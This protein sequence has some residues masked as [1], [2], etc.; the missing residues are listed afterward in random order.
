MP[1]PRLSFPTV[2]TPQNVQQQQI[3]SVSL[4]MKI[5]DPKNPN[6]GPEKI[7]TKEPSDVDETGV[8]AVLNTEDIM[9]QY[10][11]DFHTETIANANESPNI[12]HN[13][14]ME[15]S[16]AKPSEAFEK[17][18]TP[19]KSK[20]LFT[21]DCDAKKLDEITKPQFGG[22]LSAGGQ[23]ISISDDSLAQV[24]NLFNEDL[25]D[26][27]EIPKTIFGGFSSSGGQKNSISKE[28]LTQANN[29]F[30]EEHENV[31]EIPK[32]KFGGFSSA[33]GKKI[34]ISKESLDQV[35]NIFNEE[36][37]KVNEI[38]KALFGGFSSAGGKNIFISKESLAQVKNIFNDEP[39]KVNEVPTAQFGSFL[40]A[41]GGQKISICQESLV[42]VKNLFNEDPENVHV[43]PK[44][45]FCGFS[46]A[47]GKKISV[48]DKALAHVKNMFNGDIKEN[49]VD[50][51]ANDEQ[52]VEDFEV[53]EFEP[54][55]ELGL[56]SSPASSKTKRP[57]KPPAFAGFLSAKG[58]L[59]AI[60][61]DAAEKARKI[62]KE[63]DSPP[64]P[65]CSSESEIE[66]NGS[67]SKLNSITNETK[68]DIF[69]K[70]TT[71]TDLITDQQVSKNKRKLEDIETMSEMPEEKKLCYE[72]PFEDDFSVD[73]QALAE[74][75]KM[76]NG[77]SAIIS[78]TPKSKNRHTSCRLV[79][80]PEVSRKVTLSRNQERLKQMEIIKQKKNQEVVPSVEGSLHRKK[81]TKQFKLRDLQINR[82]N[83]VAM[84]SNVR[85]TTLDMTSET[86]ADH[87]FVGRQYFSDEIL[88]NQTS[89][90]MG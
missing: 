27:N 45:Q 84:T 68:K 69:I 78:T 23:K 13:G 89:I 79:G 22:F 48:S 39:E 4:N 32:A 64:T 40:S 29:I 36:P 59:L 86:A 42:Q 85:Q 73:T 26:A 83:S 8:A 3:E 62:F 52:S 46:S 31:D 6:M 60:S 61:T 72:D 7:A 66:I 5:T 49:V 12:N 76:I 20:P 19:E 67:V 1:F 14:S 50:S 88:L 24:K 65:P 63:V 18:W 57:P 16:M 41:A 58:D 70:P 9:A 2:K 82:D 77:N 30:N 37:E 56:K 87:V 75:E 90:L 33:G 25:K 34:S 51:N 80:I 15:K 21:D 43:I 44:A 11:D 17:V 71:Q 81:K 53:S 28:A 35:K 54:N 74:V 10:V 38:P 47:G 55:N